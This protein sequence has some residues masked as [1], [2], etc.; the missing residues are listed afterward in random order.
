MSV[1]SSVALFL[2]LIGSSVAFQFLIVPM[3]ETRLAALSFPSSSDNYLSSLSGGGM[4]TM[5]PPKPPPPGESSGG[6]KHK[7]L[8]LRRAMVSCLDSNN[9]TNLSSFL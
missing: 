1:V 3:K 6:F 2:S 8:Y 9:Y 5:E 4:P 7:G